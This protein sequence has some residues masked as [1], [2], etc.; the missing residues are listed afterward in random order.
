MDILDEVGNILV[1]GI[2]KILGNRVDSCGLQLWALSIW[3]LG[4]IDSEII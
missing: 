2:G 1:G 3:T 4:T